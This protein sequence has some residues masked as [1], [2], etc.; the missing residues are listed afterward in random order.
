MTKKIVT[1]LFLTGLLCCAPLFAGAIHE[2][3]WEGDL[4]KVKSAIEKD[5]ACIKAPDDST[6]QSAQKLL[7]LHLA[8]SRGYQEIIE[9][10]LE[11]GADPNAKAG[12]EGTTP[13]HIAA[14]TNNQELVEL[15]IKKGGNV[16]AVDANGATPIMK[17][18]SWGPNNEGIVEYFI[19]EKKADPNLMDAGGTNSTVLHQACLWPHNFP[20]VQMLIEKVKMDP[21]I[22]SGKGKEPIIF[23]AQSG[24]QELIEY[25]VEKGA[26]VKALDE[27]GAN[28]VILTSVHGNE[29][30]VKWLIDKGVDPKAVTMSGETALHRAVF[31]SEPERQVPVM[32]LLIEKGV[33]PKA[34][35][36]EGK[37]ALDLA[38]EGEKQVLVEYLSSL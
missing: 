31:G 7:P 18:V 26:D 20:T 14:T 35:T 1:V 12:D 15:L 8:L 4:E 9:L 30:L 25:L 21:R 16:N 17:A 19:L 29:D 3:I 33:D 27:D 24:S 6:E 11:K 38:Q 10:L 23:A 36:K 2:A 37:T 22:K 5:P 28:L 13:M 34:K 32:K